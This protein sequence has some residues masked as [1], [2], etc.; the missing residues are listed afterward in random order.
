MDSKLIA[1]I[2]PTK[3]DGKRSVG[4]GYPIGKDLV[5]TARHVVFPHWPDTQK[6]EIE[7]PDLNHTVAVT[8]VAFDGGD[9]CDIA[10]LQCETPPQ[11]HVSPLLLAR[12]LPNPHDTWEGYGYPRI[13]KDE[14]A[15]SVREK[16]SAL[17]KFH[18]PDANSHKISLTSESDAI[19]KVGWR[20]I[21]G[22]PVFHGKTLYAVITSTPTN[23][24]ECFT[25]V[26][27]PH[28]LAHNP[29]FREKAGIDQ[30]EQGFSTAIACLQQTPEAR[31]ALW[32]EIS[33]QS[34]EV[35]D[36]AN[37]I[38]AYL[39]KLPIDQ[40]IALVHTAQRGAK[41]SAVF[42]ELKQLLHVVLPSLY[43]FDCVSS[44]RASKGKISA[45]ILAIPY[46]TDISAE[47]LMAGVDR[48]PVDFMV[49]EL[50]HGRQVRAG[51]YRLPFPPESGPHDGC[52]SLDDIG[53]D[54][55]GRL[56][57]G[58][59]LASMRIAIDEHLFKLNPRKQQRAYSLPDKKKLVRAWLEN[60]ARQQRPGFYW[61]FRFGDDESENE[62]LKAFASE[63]KTSYPHITQLALD[64]DVD[65]E[66]EEY[67]LFNQLEDTQ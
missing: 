26:L 20:G 13:G 42:A 53:D 32:R 58:A 11:A 19:E 39:V 30:I 55:Y 7:W 65:R 37:S 57:G 52:Q 50:D 46:A 64:G 1:K 16:I 44:I 23:R 25:A 24:K 43:G 54:L 6:V 29:Q 18:P 62:K 27:I 51:K 61:L 41:H 5:L 10:I 45:G 49:C 40:L 66:L 21:S 67:N 59:E 47:T 17:G 15:G 48:R 22:A 8:G 56:C 38:I 60:E 28:L 4:T 2:L 35:V 9:S 14:T 31:K 3:A 33:K 63:L 34:G 12:Q 36:S